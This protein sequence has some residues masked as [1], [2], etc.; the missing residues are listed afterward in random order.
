MRR[1][2]GPMLPWSRLVEVEGWHPAEL[3][4]C[5]DTCTCLGVLGLRL[6]LET[7]YFAVLGSKV[8]RPL[9]LV[10]EHG[11]CSI[12]PFCR[13]AWTSCQR[14]CWCVCGQI[15]FV[16]WNVWRQ[17]PCWIISNT[18]WSEVMVCHTGKN[19][20]SRS[21]TGVVWGEGIAGKSRLRGTCSRIGKTASA[22]WVVAP[23]GAL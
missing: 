19:C 5:S 4:K 9:C 8:N 17:Q 11:T 14:S 10:V 7:G 12:T 18:H 16:R 20:W 15:V 3:W 13:T 22:S 1:R 2:S 23:V 6:A 21:P